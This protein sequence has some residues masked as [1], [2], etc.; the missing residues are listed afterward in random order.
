MAITE[1][2][3]DLEIEEKRA[4][5]DALEAVRAHEAPVRETSHATWQDDRGMND[6]IKRLRHQSETTQPYVDMERALIE[7]ETY[8][9]YEGAVSTPELRGLVL[10]DY[11]SK[12][13]IRIEPGELIVGEKGRG[14]QAAPTFPEL[15]CHT[16]ED[17][18]N[19]N[20]RETVN[21]KVTEDDLRAQAEI[22]IPY[23]EHRS[24]REKIM[25]NQT[26]E[27]KDA[28]EAGIFTE[29]YEQRAG[30]HTC[31]GSDRGI[32]HG[33]A[34]IKQEIQDA[35][36][37]LDFMEDEQ[38]TAKMHELKGMLYAIEA[39]TT[40][41]NRYAEL[42]DAQ[43][44]S[45]EAAGDDPVRASEL[46]QIAENCRVVATDRPKTYWQWLQRYWFIHLA[47]TTETN[48]W[49]AYTPGR[50]DQHLIPYYKADVAA[51][52]LDREHALELLEC[53]WVKFNNQPAPPKVGVTLKES[54]TY[55]DFANINTGGITPDGKNGVNDVSYIILDC[56]D[57]MLFIQPN[58]NVQISRKTPDKFLKKACEVARRGWGQPAFYNTEELIDEML[59][60]GKSL[61]DARRGGSSGCVET[62]CWGYE[63]YPLT[64]YFNLPK[65]LEVTLNDGVDPMSG[66]QIGLKTGDP[67]SFAS[68][69]ELFDAYKRQV[70]Y[71][72]DIKVRGSNVNTRLCAEANPVPFM[73]IVTED[74][75]RN[76]RDY[77][78]GGARY[79]TTYL[80][81]VGIG[82]ITDA[83]SSLKYNVYDKHVCTMDEMLDAL[84]HNYEGERYQLLY[85]KV[86]RKTPKFGND[87][88]YADTIMRAVFD[89][90]HDIITGRNNMRN[91]QWRIDML[92]T[93]CHI[94][95]GEV[96]GASPSGRKA[97]EPV[98]DGIS[99]E[100]SADVNGP[101][102][103]VKSCA[104]MDHAATGGTLL[105]QKFTPSSIAGEKG[106][107]NLSNLVRSY[108]DMDGHHIQFNVIDRET[109]L[110]AQKHPES[111]KDLIVRVAGFSEKWCNLGTELQNEI[112]NRTEQ[113]F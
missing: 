8:K 14:P 39:P 76:G 56:M 45:L 25:A 19:M 58:S 16:L 66:K 71:F 108:F 85:N 33:F 42:A 90:F 10:R 36:D 53:L 99:P 47:I 97:G 11:F 94:Y 89:Y 62:G 112:I 43:A 88:E 51:G 77:N 106:I 92:P 27:W 52:I 102:A 46:R 105:N 64:G 69:D 40:L 20:D 1:S 22:V 54:G 35:L 81:G 87:D 4:I 111:Y 38:A 113:S 95:F 44:A 74:C 37:A 96:T 41:A 107:D 30:G 93:T 6:R 68:F 60:A 24:S 109:L 17:M 9:R 79:N 5:E 2:I 86:T 110:D 13:T 98:S 28:F 82:S 49:D 63:A 101:T 73:S 72:A 50:L 103:V 57:E 78:D 34:E 75:I 55:S 23:W 26:R 70:K 100:R 3:K 21:F 80:Q 84:A 59:T 29:F 15:C 48:P 91:G 65:I 18:H 83:L 31:L 61:A 104:K 32:S 7:T 12:K 67:R